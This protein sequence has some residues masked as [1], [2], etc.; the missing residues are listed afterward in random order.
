VFNAS[1]MRGLLPY[2]QVP[3]ATTAGSSH[4]IDDARVLSAAWQVA[5][6]VNLNVGASRLL[7]DYPILGIL[8]TGPA[9][10]DTTNRLNLGANW[11]IH[12]KVDLSATLGREE[13]LSNISGSN[14]R[15][16]VLGVTA[17]LIY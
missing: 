15:D 14:Y 2:F 7:T 13:R 8:V 1:A 11:S 9:R 17:S 12:P 10:R 3:T 5:E 16:T 4:R 6:K